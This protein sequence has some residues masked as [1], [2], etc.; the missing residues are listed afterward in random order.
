[1]FSER[2]AADKQDPLHSGYGSHL[3]GRKRFVMAMAWPACDRRLQQA[4]AMVS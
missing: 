4:L 1:M 3:A 2:L